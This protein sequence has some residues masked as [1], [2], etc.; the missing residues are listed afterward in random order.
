MHDGSFTV[1]SIPLIHRSRHCEPFNVYRGDLSSLV[2]TDADGLPDNGFGT[3]VNHLD[4]DT[5]DNVFVDEEIPLPGD[6]FFYLMARVDALGENEL[7]ATSDGQPRV[8]AIPCQ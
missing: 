2:D 5:T 3:C 6:G 7:G 8:P 1:S 4:P